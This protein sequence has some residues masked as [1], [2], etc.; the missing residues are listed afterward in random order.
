ELATPVA[1]Q[2]LE[3]QLN[4]ALTGDP[5][6]QS[7]YWVDIVAGLRR[8]NRA[9]ALPAVLQCADR[10]IELPQ[11]AMLAAE[12]IAFPNFPSAL[13]QPT[14]T[15]GRMALRVLVAAACAG[16]DG[17]LDPS[18]LARAGLGDTLASVAEAVERIA[19]PWLTLAVIEAERIFRRLGH[20]SRFLSPEVRPLAER[21]AMRLWA[22][23]DRRL[24]WLAGAGARLLA[25]FPMADTREQAVSLRCLVEL[26]A[27]VTRLFPHL[28]DHRLPWWS[29]AIRAL[30]W[31]ASLVVGPVFASQASRL[32]R[33]AKNHPRAVAL[34]CALRGHACNEAEWALLHAA[35]AEELTLRR[36]AISSL[37]WWPPFDPDAVVR[38]LR[39]TRTDP[40][41][42][43]R[44]FA[45]AALARL[46]ERTALAEVAAGLASEEAS[47]RQSTA[48]T[49]ASEELTW[50]WPE[51]E[52][53]TESADPDTALAACEAL[54]RLRERFLG[55]TK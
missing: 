50:L 9:E 3:R 51:L 46:G 24:E 15:I 11:G 8:L 42:E 37:G 22:T 16:R 31:S 21:Q 27:D 36:A 20:W 19:D 49:I 12:V 1:A 17:V 34:L 7:W 41:A 4:R 43:L 18:T 32:A 54:E 30:Q 26:R 14:S 10:A 44:R 25:R 5:V 28:P 29:E 6:E 45:V 23:A 2:V 39:V 35:H 13:Q 47:I 53:A 38:C 48:M 33:K 55:L 52:T 40:N